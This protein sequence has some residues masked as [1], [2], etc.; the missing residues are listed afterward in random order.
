M[1][2]ALVCSTIGLAALV[3]SSFAEA[4][5]LS[6]LLKGDLRTPVEQ[7]VREDGLGMTVFELTPEAARRM[8][9]Q[10]R[11]KAAV[12][13]IVYTTIL[14]PDITGG[15]EAFDV[16]PLEFTSYYYGFVV[17]NLGN[18]PH[19]GNVSFSLNGPVKWKR[20]FNNVSINGGTITV[21]WIEANP[22]NRVGSYQITGVMSGAGSMKSRFCAGC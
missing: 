9:P 22:L 14:K 17:A 21:L 4:Q 15:I 11:G 13:Y 2:R 16:T 18:S 10:Q 8:R 3:C 5:E 12:P 19:V 6:R 1:R 20:S 7:V